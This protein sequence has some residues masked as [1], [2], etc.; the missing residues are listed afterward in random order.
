MAT[1]ADSD[2]PQVVRPEP[3]PPSFL[4]QG[5]T[6]AA[7]AVHTFLVDL[8]LIGET[9]LGDLLPML[10]RAEPHDAAAEGG[11]FVGDAAAMF[12]GALEMS[13]GTP[14][15]MAGLGG[16]LLL[17]VV[18]GGQG[19]GVVVGG[20]SLVLG[21]GLVLHGG[22]VV[23]GGGRH[24]AQ[25]LSKNQGAEG[26]GSQQKPEPKTATE[27]PGQTANGQA[28]DQHG[29]KLGPSGKPMIHETTST[30]REGARNKA[31][32]EGAGA[33]EHR[34]PSRGLGHFHPTD[35][36]G[37]KKPGSTHHNYPD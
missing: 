17:E 24:A 3:P 16:G 33:V 10:K 31:L 29:N 30:T 22:T 21:G 32:A 37:K 7:F 23:V 19:A 5:V 13:W 8:A 35:N 36:K 28:T 25:Y 20:A 9:P 26:G 1:P 12:W 34:K 11:Q 14:I 18:P 15:L 6:A 4:E 2:L 27:A